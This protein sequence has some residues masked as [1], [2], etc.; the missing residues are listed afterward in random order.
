MTSAVEIVPPP[1]GYSTTAASTPQLFR[2]WSKGAGFLVEL[3]GSSAGL[4][5]PAELS[6]QAAVLA[7][8]TA[9]K[10]RSDGDKVESS[11]TDRCHPRFA[12]A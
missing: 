12:S 11:K 1:P 6:R 5:E 8:K 10:G 7:K 3:I 9:E 4:E 2:D